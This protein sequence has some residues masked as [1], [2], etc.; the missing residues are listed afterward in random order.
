MK[1]TTRF[2]KFQK[3]L[4]LGAVLLCVSTQLSSGR[5]ILEQDRADVD[6]FNMTSPRLNDSLMGALTLDSILGFD[7]TSA[8][9]G[10]LIFRGGSSQ[11]RTFI[12]DQDMPRSV[13]RWASLES[14]SVLNADFLGSSQFFVSPGG[15][16][17]SL[18]D[19]LPNE[20]TVVVP[21]ASTWVSAA[22]A[23]AVMGFAR[24]RWLRGLI[25]RT[26]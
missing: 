23:L 20:P 12:P 11:F 8:R 7:L 17:G 9:M 13:G 22:L 18:G 6:L 14:R 5:S 3:I 24:R 10:T 16:F 26:A 25:T 15:G 2:G 21:E 4:L 1:T 19:Q